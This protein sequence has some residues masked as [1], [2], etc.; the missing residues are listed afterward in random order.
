MFTLG[1]MSEESAAWPKYGSFLV[2]ELFSV[3]DAGGDP[4]HFVQALY[5][6]HAVPMGH[7]TDTLMPW[8]EFVKMV[9]RKGLSGFE[10]VKKCKAA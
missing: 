9:E 1:L 3:E 6:G 7:S 4:K 10:W 5:N 8:A 2:L